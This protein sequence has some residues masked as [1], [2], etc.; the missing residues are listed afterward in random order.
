MGAMNL[1]KWS[2]KFTTF[3]VGV[4]AGA[5]LAL[6]FAPS[7]GEETRDYITGSLKKGLDD[8]A[9]TGKRWTRQAQEKV[10]DVK[11][12]V[13]DAVEAGGKAYRAAAG[14]V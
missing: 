5:L 9:S 2:N 3:A 1:N 6:L 10:N 7:S 14:E 11:A 13:T 12:N 4:G 8:A